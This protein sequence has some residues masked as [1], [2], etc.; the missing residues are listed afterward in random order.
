MAREELI[1]R[2]G[3][4]QA[5][6]ARLRRQAAAL[7]SRGDVRRAAELEHQLDAAMAEETRLRQLIDRSR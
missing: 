1:R 4:V 2:K 6:V 7:R 3:E 5:E